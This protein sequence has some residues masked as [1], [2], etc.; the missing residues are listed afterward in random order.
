MIF[1]IMT[2]RRIKRTKDQVIQIGES[3]HHHDQVE[4]TP[5]PASL[6]PMKIRVRSPVNP[7]PDEVF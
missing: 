2:I 7:I 1:T 3:T 4:T 5:I 6:S